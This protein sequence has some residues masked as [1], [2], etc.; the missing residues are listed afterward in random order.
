MHANQIHYLPVHPLFYAI[1]LGIIAGL[2]VLV[3]LGV[4]N[5]AYRRLGLGPKGAM[6]LLLGS[7]LGGYVNIPIAQLPAERIRASEE[8]DLFGFH[9]VAPVVA[10][11]PGTIV[12][13]NVGGAVIPTLLS[14]YLLARHRIWF[15][16]L[17]A[18]AIVAL[19]THLMARPVAGVGV[20]VPIFVPPLVTAVVA[21][22]VSRDYA[23]PIAYV[24]GSLGTLIGADL[25]HLD[26]INRL[27]APVAAI[28]GAGT[29]DGIFLTGVIAVLLAGSRRPP[30]PSDFQRAPPR[31]V[32]RAPW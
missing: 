16:G 15:S 32:P 6:F 1:F 26:D 11:W 25:L 18:T 30:A 20:T 7:L 12:A 29:F 3:Q 2:F 10:D 5:Y 27:G 14:I 4:L 22:L 28:G 19:A 31:S 21:L 17:V 24:S 23:A 13:V 9:Y 8:F